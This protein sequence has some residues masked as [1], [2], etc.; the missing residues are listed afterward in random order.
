MQVLL[1]YQLISGAANSKTAFEIQLQ[2]GSSK[3]LAAAKANKNLSSSGV[4]PPFVTANAV[5]AL[6]NSTKHYV[7]FKASVANCPHQWFIYIG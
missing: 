2:E 5:D 4:H 1:N 6:R 7:K 3:T